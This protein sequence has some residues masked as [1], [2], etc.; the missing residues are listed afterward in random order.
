MIY[1]DKENERIKEKNLNFENH[2]KSHEILVKKNFSL[3]LRINKKY[4]HS[5]KIDKKS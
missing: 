4:S 2:A 3:N 1:T 5:L